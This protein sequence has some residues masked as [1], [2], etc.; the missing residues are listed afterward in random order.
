MKISDFG[1]SKIL[2]DKMA[3]TK[4]GTIYTMAPEVLVSEDRNYDH[5]CDI[6]SL[7]IIYYYLLYR[8]LPWFKYTAS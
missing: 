1:G 3:H 8:K 4:V 2:L 6:W 5:K 7:G